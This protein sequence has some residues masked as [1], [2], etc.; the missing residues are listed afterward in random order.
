[1]DN[2]YRI[3]EVSKMYNISIDALRYYDK[4]GLIKPIIDKDSDYRYY[5][6]K[7]FDLL[8]FVLI[9]KAL[10]VPL[11]K[12][13]D[14][15]ETQDINGYEELF[16][17]QRAIIDEKMKELTQMRAINE[18]LIEITHEMKRHKNM[19]DLSNLQVNRDEKRF[20][21]LPENSDKEWEDFICSVNFINSF[22]FYEKSNGRYLPENTD[23]MIVSFTG[24]PISALETKLKQ[25]GPITNSYKLS[26]FGKGNKVCNFLGTH[27]E[28]Q[29]YLIKLSVLS[30]DKTESF[31]VEYLF[32]LYGN[33]AEDNIYFTKILFV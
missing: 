12:V 17:E 8:E 6:K 20:Y 23:H 5:S 31:L 3:G 7:H 18:E 13:K 19:L 9:S 21:F 33:H 29:D 15:I 27:S 16:I 25:M 1:M 14:I 30:T 4:I 2:M 11:K 10:G 28:L 32:S 26:Q 22:I 24:K